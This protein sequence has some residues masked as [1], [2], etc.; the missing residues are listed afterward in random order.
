ML[1][2]IAALI[3]LILW[4][5]IIALAKLMLLISMAYVIYTILKSRFGSRF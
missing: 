4:G 2:L 1:L 5:S 3:A